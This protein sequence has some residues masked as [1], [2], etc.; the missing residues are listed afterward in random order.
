MCVYFKSI[1]VIHS[2]RYALRHLGYSSTIWRVALLMQHTICI[3]KI[4]IFSPFEKTGKDSDAGRGW[5]QE[6]KGTT[7]DEMAGWH[8]WLDGHESEWTP[9]VGDGQGDLVCCDSWGCKESDMTERL[10]WTE[11]TV[12]TG[13]LQKELC[14]SLLQEKDWI[15]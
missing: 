13:F 9:G 5:G 12:Q 15:L 8:H 10:N 3:L 14:F 4:K 6:E 11:M 2:F 7:E 1:V